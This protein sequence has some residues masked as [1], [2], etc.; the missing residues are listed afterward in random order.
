MVD[1]EAARSAVGVGRMALALAFALMAVMSASCGGGDGTDST[2]A[3]GAAA[4]ETT[5][6]TVAP[7]G[8][9]PE[10]SPVLPVTVT[11]ADGVEVTIDDASRIIPVN[12]DIAEVVFALGLG[13]QVVATD[14]SATYPPEADALPEIGYQR[15]LLAERIIDLEPTVVVANTD[16]GPPEVLEQLRDAGIAVVV[17][18]YPHDLTGPAAKIRLVAQALGVPARGEALAREVDATIATATDRAAERVAAAEAAGDE[19]RR[20]AFL[21]LRGTNV[22]QVGGRGSGVDALLEAAAWSTW[23]SSWASTSSSRSPTRPCSPRRPTCSW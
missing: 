19:P 8:S 1:G 5:V 12:G 9:E 14:L 7:A 6:G 2:D 17:V 4:S 21:Y 11:G 13:D 16:A 3:A 10:A 15:T 23:A 18:E 20:A 22:Q